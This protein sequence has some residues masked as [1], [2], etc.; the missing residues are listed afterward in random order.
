MAVSKSPFSKDN[1]S[2]AEP[3]NPLSLSKQEKQDNSLFSTLDALQV[4]GSIKAGGSPKMKTSLNAETHKLDS[5]YRGAMAKISSSGMSDGEKKR[6]SK[7]LQEIYTTGTQKT[8]VSNNLLSIAKTGIGGAFGAVN[9]VFEAGSAVSRY[10]QS[11]IKE[12]SD[13]VMYDPNAQGVDKMDASWSDFFNQAKKDSGFKLLPKTGVKWVDS[14]IDFGVDQVFDPLNYIGVGEVKWTGKAGRFALLSKLGTKEMAATY[15]ELVGKLDDIARFGMG[16]VPKTVREGEGLAFGVRFAGVQVPKT[17]AVAKFVSGRKGLTTGVRTFVSDKGAALTT[18]L[19]LAGKFTPVTRLNLRIAEVGMNKGIA[20][21]VVRQHIAEYTAAKYAKGFKSA[22]YN[23]ATRRIEGL[24]K[25]VR[26]AG[27]MEE[28]AMLADDAAA[29]ALEPDAQL[30]QWATD[31]RKWQD[32]LLGEINSV[33][34]RFNK[35]FGA[36]MKLIN[37]IDD[38]GIHHKMTSDAFKFAYGP[39]GRASGFFKD[40]DLTPM[41]LG[42]NTGAAMFRRYK[43]G[44]QFM[45]ETLDPANGGI[46]KQ[47]NE[48]FKRKTGNDFNF[49]E[50]D[51]TN[52]A[53]S[54][55]YSLS[56]KR[57]QEAYVRRML[58]FGDDVAKIINK[59]MV[60]DGDLVKQLSEAHGILRG[61]HADLKRIVNKGRAVAVDKTREVV[62]FAKVALDAKDAEAAVLNNQVGDVLTKLYKVETSLHGAAEA[63][64]LKSGEARGAFDSIWGNMIDDVRQ[65]RTNIEQGRI[66]EVAAQDALRSIYTKMRPDAQRVPK[67]ASRLLDLVQRSEGVGDWTQVRE[68]EKRLKAVQSQLAETAGLNPQDLNDLMD[69]EQNLLRQID[70]FRQLGDVKMNASYAED[71]LLHGTMDDLV[72][73]T[74]DPNI[75]YFDR[76]N[77]VMSTQPISPVGPDSSTDELAALYHAHITDPN[78]VAVHAIRET[79]VID[80]RQ[81][82]HFYDFWNPEMGVGEAVD[83]ALR[84]AGLDAEEMFIKTWDT[85]LQGGA[86]DPMFEQVYPELSNILTFIG[87]VHANDFPTGIVADDFNIATFETLKDLFTETAAAAEVAQ[88][89]VVGQQMFD[90]F[91]RAMVEEGIGNTGRPVLLPSSA[92]FGSENPMAIDAFSV[93]LPDS[94]NYASAYGEKTITDA[95]I[96]GTDSPVFLTAQDEFIT[97]I[98]GNGYHTSS[99]DANE[100]LSGVG[101]AGQQLQADLAQR[102]GAVSEARTIGGQ[103]G[104]IKS[105]GSRR[106]RAAE[107]AYADFEASG[108]VEFTLAGK[109]MRMPRDKAVA[110]LA[111]SEAKTIRAVTQLEEKLTRITQGEIAPVLKRKAKLE[112]RLGTLFNQRKVIENWNAQTGDALRAEIEVMQTA[113]ATDAPTGWAGTSSRQWAER[114]SKAMNNVSSLNGSASKDAW[115]RVVTQLGAD[116]AQLAL[117]ETTEL[118]AAW[119]ALKMAESGFFGGHIVDDIE[120][121]W[122][123]LEGTGIQLPEEFHAIIQPNVTKLKKAAERRDYFKIYKTYNGLFKI[124]ATMTPGFVVRNAMSATFMNKVAGVENSAIYD[125]TRAALAYAKHGPDKWLNELGIKDLADREIYETAMRAVLA[126][127]RINS[128]FANP[129][130]NKGWADKLAHNKLTNL[131]SS[132][133]ELVES[134]VRL[135][136]ALDTLRKGNNYDDAIYRIS[137]FHFDYTDLSSFDETMK[138][139]IPFWVWTSRNLPLQMTEQFMRPRYYNMYADIQDRNP[140]AADVMLPAWARTQG[141]IGLGGNRVLMA[142]MP[143]NRLQQTAEGF[144][145]PSK[146]IGQ[147]NPLVK[148]LPEMMA[149]KNLALDVPFTDKY[150]QAKGLDKLVAGLGAI[151]GAEGL[152]RMENGK[153]MVSP[154][155]SYALGNLV[156]TVSSLQRLTGGATGGKTTY[157]ERQGS[158]LLSAAGVPMRN[159]GPQQQRGE[160]IGRQFTIADLMK[161]IA[162][163]G[164]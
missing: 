52:V 50:T 93:I 20:D 129:V 51:L 94:Y 109:K 56:A 5:A 10:A 106:V 136:M 138:N 2:K 147:A 34:T 118:P 11:G 102:A 110:E 65:L 86:V 7:A 63:A 1:S 163:K 9:K 29:L 13:I 14:V 100:L 43:H 132:S 158:S 67:S 39:K 91:M 104:G 157:A 152:G 107:K 137:R 90:D 64:A 162:R 111:K 148:L 117:L 87:A 92:I 42:G 17:E 103:I 33:R 3:Y 83:Y 140:V 155:A 160:T 88:S 35:D 154:K 48:I 150:E 61:V 22:T 135:P 114:T 68:L 85:A 149:N 131:L 124:Y 98:L 8:E 95:M 164:K 66:S 116:E 79:D 57:G 72:E 24:V 141:A 82:E 73:V 159:F 15:P 105:A 77:R 99:L 37:S 133:N 139:F 143:M 38:Y 70:G 32:D 115:E 122:K 46:I 55:A 97:E 75:P 145:S 121:G 36:D 12:L 153:L 151:T 112:E 30:R 156:P 23:G 21:N 19:D 69:I 78:S 26:T 41:E 4:A 134:S 16:A 123:A 45:G 126:T 62:Q 128:D 89:E 76:K 27:K 101:E 6:A 49:F 47:V 119:D 44:E 40:A 120:Q 127:G 84:R 113:I 31:Y 96:E 53:D 58:D 18:K 80:M 161:E 25:D 59:Q 142:D 130:L 54:Y 108:M 81:P 60:P 71:G 146:L 74:P 144:A 125:G 28:V